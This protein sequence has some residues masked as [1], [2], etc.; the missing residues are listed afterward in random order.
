MFLR[1]GSQQPAEKGAVLKSFRTLP[2][3]ESCLHTIN[4]G[5]L[6]SNCSVDG[7]DI[8]PPEAA[9]QNDASGT[10]EGTVESWEIESCKESVL[11]YSPFP[12]W[13]R[14]FG[15]TSPVVTDPDLV[16]VTRV[17]T[18]SD[19]ENEDDSD[20][21]LGQTGQGETTETSFCLHK[22]KEAD[23]NSDQVLH[24]DS[25]GNESQTDL[26]VPVLTAKSILK[27]SFKDS[28][29]LK[30]SSSNRRHSKQM[31]FS[32]DLSGNS[33][34]YERHWE[35]ADLATGDMGSDVSSSSSHTARD[36]T[37]PGVAEDYHGNEDISSSYV[38]ED[39][40]YV[41]YSSGNYSSLLSSHI[42]SHEKQ[43][44]RTSQLPASLSVKKISHTDSESLDYSSPISPDS[45]PHPGSNITEGHSCSDQEQSPV[46]SMPS[47]I[48]L[49]SQG[50][51]Q[52]MPVTKRT[53]TDPSS[54]PS[55]RSLAASTPR[56]PFQL[57]ALFSGLR[58]LKKGA[59]GEERETV[60]EIKQ[61]DTDRALLSLKQH[62]NKA[63]SEQQTAST[64]T[65]KKKAESKDVSE[66]RSRLW[67]L[68]NF[69]DVRNEEN[70]DR[71]SKDIGSLSSGKE[72]LAGNVTEADNQLNDSSKS[73][74]TA[75]D[76]FKFFFSPKPLKKDPGDSPVDLESVRRKRK[77]EKELLKS[78]FE[79]STS[80]SPS[81]DKSTAEIKVCI[82]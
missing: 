32:F 19:T 1:A 14:P 54:T 30:T 65:P 42:S 16:Q 55:S 12:S 74:D 39:P 70:L 56:E 25:W 10:F 33:K 2:E 38:S 47:A 8:G 40:L 15:T 61:R 11:S 82:T 5:N 41:P 9:A 22:D 62:V 45:A 51:S 60:S 63:K 76:A 69:D 72:E 68:L 36:H 24:H 78:I 80:K 17:E 79:K 46:D 6:E 81:S 29:V 53:T 20:G 48:S 27:Q 35:G 67:R 23:H 58:V 57:P 34:L 64:L 49:P 26:E 3:E 4:N 28:S 71:E 75:F 18:Y 31:D 50:S 43:S 59:A 37:N 7:V 13:R 66:P 44:W 73:T 77:N 52:E 21:N